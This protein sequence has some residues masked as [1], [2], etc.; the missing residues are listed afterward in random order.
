MK[1]QT[2]S[3]EQIAHVIYFIRGQK[4]L[5]D[6]DL[7]ALYGVATRV[8]NQAVK[9]NKQRFPPDFMFRLN[10]AE[11]NFLRSQFVTSSA[12]PLIFHLEYQVG[13]DAAIFPSPLPSKVWP[14]SQACSTASARSK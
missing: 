11:Y 9:R 5:L 13:A 12:P 3:A 4:M 2:A 6:H 7:A 8:L 10:V 14:C 1:K